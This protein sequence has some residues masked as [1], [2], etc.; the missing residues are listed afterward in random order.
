MKYNHFCQR[1]R[2]LFQSRVQEG[3]ET[4]PCCKKHG[5]DVPVGFV[6]QDY[7]KRTGMSDLIK[8]KEGETY[9]HRT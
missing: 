1:C 9:D 5:W 4:A 6:K 3:P 8:T 7:S 2:L